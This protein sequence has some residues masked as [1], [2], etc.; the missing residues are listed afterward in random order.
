MTFKPGD[1]K[2]ARSGRRKGVKNKIRQ[3]LKERIEKLYPNYCPIEA[4]CRIAQESGDPE[5]RFAADKA[6][7][8]YLYPRQKSVEHSGN[9]NVNHS[10]GDILQ[11]RKKAREA[12]KHKEGK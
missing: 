10:L 12:A 6:V 7:A 5:I 3:D 2:P 9:V 8:S 1:P 11:Q 4:M